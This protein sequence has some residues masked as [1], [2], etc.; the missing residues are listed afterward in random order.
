MCLAELPWTSIAVFLRPLFLPTFAKDPLQWN[1]GCYNGYRNFQA[2]N[3]CYGASWS[4]HRTHRVPTGLIACI[5]QCIV[6]LCR[7]PKAPSPW[8]KSKTVLGYVGGSLL[9]QVP[10]RCPTFIRPTPGGRV[11]RSCSTWHQW[12]CHGGMVQRHPAHI[13]RQRWKEFVNDFLQL[14]PIVCKL[15]LVV[16]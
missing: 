2:P 11:S 8:Q 14:P 5:I 13:R 7:W 16:Q 1:T 15:S 10:H 4:T 9:A 12:T 6:C 3:L